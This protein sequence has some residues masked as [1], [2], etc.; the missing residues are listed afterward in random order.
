M[1]FLFSASNRRNIL[2][3]KEF[4]TVY[5]LMLFIALIV[6][7]TL[8]L[9]PWLHKM[10]M[11]SEPGMEISQCEAQIWGLGRSPPEIFRFFRAPY[12][13]LAISQY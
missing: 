13:I 1:I 4:G 12:A 10:L 11:C 9:S 8:K 7:G 2:K 5:L 3:L 6:L